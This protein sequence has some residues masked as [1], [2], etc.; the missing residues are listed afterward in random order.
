MFIKACLVF[1]RHRQREFMPD[2]V[3][4][5]LMEEAAERIIHKHER[6][7]RPEPGYQLRLIFDNVPVSLF[8]LPESGFSCH[9]PGPFDRSRY[10]VG[11]GGSKILFKRA[12]DPHFT[13]MLMAQ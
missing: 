1:A 8:A 9:P 11:N 12:P 7:V 6:P 10:Q 4:P 13:G 2:Y 5:V 3:V